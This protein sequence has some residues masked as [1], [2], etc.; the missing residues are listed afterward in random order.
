MVSAFHSYFNPW[1]ENF[2]RSIVL[3]FLLMHTSQYSKSSR[4]KP[5]IML[6]YYVI[7]PKWSDTGQSGNA[8]HTIIF[9]VFL[10]FCYLFW[11]K[12]Q[13]RGFKSDKAKNGANFSDFHKK[14]GSSIWFWG[15]TIQFALILSKLVTF[16]KFS[17]VMLIN[18]LKR[19]L[20][21]LSVNQNIKNERSL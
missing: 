13:R 4:I 3:Q 19:A 1:S 6:Y 7:F 8:E 17:S 12:P 9:V 21:S 5:Q 18:I 15:M 10:H 14:L 20:F 11:P 2:T 16:T